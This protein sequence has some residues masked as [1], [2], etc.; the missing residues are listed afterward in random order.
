MAKP[1]AEIKLEE[2]QTLGAQRAD[3]IVDWNNEQAVLKRLAWL[4][5]CKETVTAEDDGE[6]PSVA[7]VNWLLGVADRGIVG[8][9][10]VVPAPAGN[11]FTRMKNYLGDNIKKG[12]VNIKEGRK[13]KKYAIMFAGMGIGAIAGA[14]LGTL[15]FPGIGTAIGGAVG[16]V[17]AAASPIVLGVI[18]GVVGA[19][20]G[21]FLSKKVASALPKGADDYKLF[22]EP[23]NRLKLLTGLDEIELTK[24]QAFVKNR[25]GQFPEGN[26]LRVALKDVRGRAFK[27]GSKAAMEQLTFFL[28][29]E[30]QELKANP[31]LA[32]KQDIDLLESV[33]DKIAQSENID[34]KVKDHIKAS[35]SEEDSDLESELA[36]RVDLPLHLGKKHEIL[37]SYESDQL[38][39]RVQ[40]EKLL[41][42]RIKGAKNFGELARAF[43]LHDYD[44]Q[45]H[46]GETVQ[47]SKVVKKLRAC[48]K[49]QEHGST[50]R[51]ISALRLVDDEKYGLYAKA[52]EL[53]VRDLVSSKPLFSRSST[54]SSPER[55]SR[56]EPVVTD[57]QRASVSSAG[58]KH[59]H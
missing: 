24:L 52:Q 40:A 7:L 22:Q 42:L 38:E 51:S 12:A 29:Q 5:A 45:D 31:S 56:A 16:G 6:I 39:I 21:T 2:L 37:Q 27:Q 34:S 1:R 4:K 11:I 55:V 57:E 19:F 10:A 35:L 59:K 18:V 58:P 13:R 28:V 23:T 47:L 26:P 14:L 15:V 49:A 8:V 46:R 54:S 36:V 53:G 43:E 32:K 48:E 17:I 25:E 30:L 44:L 33:L 41:V 3:D 50:I 9:A 20:L